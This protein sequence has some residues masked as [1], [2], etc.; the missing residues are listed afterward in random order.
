[1]CLDI[2]NEEIGLRVDVGR[3]PILLERSGAQRCRSTYL[4][5]GV[6]VHTIIQSGCATIDGISDSRGLCVT[7]DG[8]V[9]GAGEKSAVY[10]EPG[11]F[12]GTDI[13]GTDVGLTGRGVFKVA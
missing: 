1:M 10:T 6:V 4:Y 3:E 7:G 8:D 12:N 13:G 9:E 2:R 11:V 5:R